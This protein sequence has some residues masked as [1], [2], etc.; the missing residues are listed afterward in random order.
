[1][2]GGSQEGRGRDHIGGE[3]GVTG[4]EGGVTGGEDHKRGEGGV[5]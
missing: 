5:T 1:M 4:G 3:G 2:R